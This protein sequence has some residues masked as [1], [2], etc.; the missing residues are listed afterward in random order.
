M[1]NPSLERAGKTALV[2]IAVLAVAMALY[3]HLAARRSRQEADRAVTARQKE[4]FAA[5]RAE[6]LEKLEAERAQEDAAGEP[7]NQPL[8]G[9]VLRRGESG[10]ALQQVPD[11]RE[12]Q[13]AALVRLQES[14]DALERQTAQSDRALRHDLEE[15]RAGV[16][17][18]QAASRNVQGLLL[19]ALIPLLV[20]LLAS[21]WQRGDGR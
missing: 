4:E 10:S 14:L 7:D 16:R 12:A 9:T 17:R 13:R 5:S 19:V 11:S 2:V 21:L 15:L 20:H 3:V 1:R 8:P 18:E 6:A